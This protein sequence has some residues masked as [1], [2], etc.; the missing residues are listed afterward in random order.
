[1][2][3]AG[4]EARGGAFLCGWCAQG[5]RLQCVGSLT[6]LRACRYVRN[7][8][9]LKEI[10]D[11]LVD[12]PSLGDLSDR[13]AWLSWSLKHQQAVERGR[14]PRAPTPGDETASLDAGHEALLALTAQANA[15]SDTH[16][17]RKR[18]SAALSPTEAS[19]LRLS[20]HAH[21]QLMA[22]LRQFERLASEADTAEPAMSPRPGDAAA[23]RGGSAHSDG[24]AQQQGVSSEDDHPHGGACNGAPQLQSVA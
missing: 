24:D 17:V 23:A 22:H 20:H 21:A 9:L 3:A 4:R 14:A 15:A 11:E 13:G 5:P 7:A 6:A 2:R 10:F 8:T 18:L 19:S 1:M 12:V 16:E